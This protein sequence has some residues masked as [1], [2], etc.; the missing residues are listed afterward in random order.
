MLGPSD[1]RTITLEDYDVDGLIYKIDKNLKKFHGWYPWES[2]LLE[3]ELPLE[4]RNEIAIKYLKAGWIYVYHITTSENGERAGL[5]SFHLSQS[6]I[7]T[8][9]RMFL[10]TKNQMNDNEFVIYRNDTLVQTI[11]K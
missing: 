8:D 6:P 11:S 5:T 2:A 4:I 9:S 1:M 3:E 10:V 7:E